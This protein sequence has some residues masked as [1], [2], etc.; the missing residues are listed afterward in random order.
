MTSRVN[1]LYPTVHFSLTAD[2]HPGTLPRIL[3]VFERAGLCPSLL[4]A[5]QFV[6][7]QTAVD[8]YTEDLDDWLQERLYG[9]LSALVGIS[10]L[11]TEVILRAEP[12]KL[13]S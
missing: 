4:K 2:N 12:R 5:S 13:A 1:Y 3:A 10:H 8:I 11:R 7:G 9:K 6:D